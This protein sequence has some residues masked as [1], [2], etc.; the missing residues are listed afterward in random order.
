MLKFMHNKLLRFGAILLIASC[1]LS[2]W[3]NEEMDLPPPPPKKTSWK[4]NVFVA[5]AFLAAAA[6]IVV[7]CLDGGTSNGATRRLNHRDH[8]D[9]DHHK[10][11]NLELNE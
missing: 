11:L 5:S 6:G 10:R 8:H 2:T 4:A 3:S 1:P 9:H 7:I